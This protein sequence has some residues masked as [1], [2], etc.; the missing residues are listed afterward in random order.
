MNAKVEQH[1][2]A[3]SKLDWL[4]WII[5]VALVAAGVVGNSYFEAEP[6]LY[7]VIGLIVL[8][9][10][11]GFFAS[12]TAQGKS[13]LQLLKEAQSEAKKVVWPNRQETA[14]TTLIVLVVVVV[15]AAF[16]FFIDWALNLGIS[17][18]VG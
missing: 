17:A 4:K 10:V 6:L 14:Q 12:M 1:Q 9:I 13:F 3:Q 15:M 8:A 18:L 16:L 7:R 5:A 11:A 2:E